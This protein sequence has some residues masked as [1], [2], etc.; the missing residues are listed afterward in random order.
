MEIDLNDLPD[1]NMPS[2][3]SILNEVHVVLFYHKIT[4]YTSSFWYYL[5]KGYAL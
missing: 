1:V 5:S 2:L 3:E 4:C